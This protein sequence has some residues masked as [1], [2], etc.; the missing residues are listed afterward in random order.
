MFAL[1]D[2]FMFNPENGCLYHPN[3]YDTSWMILRDGTWVPEEWATY[4][5]DEHAKNIINQINEMYVDSYCY[6]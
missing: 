6:S 2:G 5:E 1:I 4:L 3:G